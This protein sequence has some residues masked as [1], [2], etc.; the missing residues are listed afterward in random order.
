LARQHTA[1]ALQALADIVADP[2]AP[3]GARVAAAEATLDR[4][5]G[6][7]TQMID[8]EVRSVS[9]ADLLTQRAAVILKEG[10]SQGLF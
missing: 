9:L 3:P 8:A 4:G 1:A 2:S 10:K 6:R 5:Y 7:P